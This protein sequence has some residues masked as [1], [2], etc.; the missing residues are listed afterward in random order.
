MAF[1]WCCGDRVCVVRCGVLVSTPCFDGDTCPLNLL[2]FFTAFSC[3]S[4]V[5]SYVGTDLVGVE[6]QRID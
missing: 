6:A 2:E 5:K 1:H 4:R 3:M